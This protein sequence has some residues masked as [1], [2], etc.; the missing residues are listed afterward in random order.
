MLTA[1]RLLQIILLLFGVNQ[2]VI[3]AELNQLSSSHPISNY[4]TEIQE[5]AL[6]LMDKG[7]SVE[8]HFNKVRAKLQRWQKLAEECDDLTS[9]DGAEFDS[10]ACKNYARSA[11]PAN[12]ADY[13]QRCDRLIDWYEEKQTELLASQAVEGREAANLSMA[14][15]AAIE[16]LEYEVGSVCADWSSSFFSDDYRHIVQLEV[17]GDRPASDFVRQWRRDHQ[18]LWTVEK[19]DRYGRERNGDQSGIGRAYQNFSGVPGGPW[20]SRPSR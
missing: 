11:R 7:W 16:Q 6:Q 5:R 8:R 2:A 4:P 9:V 18:D 20:R 19:F 17:N 10:V 13:L 12:L 1:S 15:T 3:A 14:T